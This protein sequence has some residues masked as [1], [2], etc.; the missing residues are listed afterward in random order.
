M[1]IFIALEF[2][3]KLR[4]VKIRVEENALFEATFKRGEGSMPK[5]TWKKEGKG[6]EESKRIKMSMV[7]TKITMKVIKTQMD[8]TG[9]YSVRMENEHGSTEC[10]AQLIIIGK[11]FNL[12][13]IAFSDVTDCL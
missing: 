2:T 11:L 6:M 8:D 13:F 9:R 10:A 3:E 4:D 5:T 1:L 7:N 12:Y